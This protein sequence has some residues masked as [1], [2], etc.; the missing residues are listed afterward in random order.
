M[1]AKIKSTHE[2]VHVTTKNVGP[3]KGKVFVRKANMWL[4]YCCFNDGKT[5]IFNWV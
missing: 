3:F 4:E 1:S 5:D 2:R